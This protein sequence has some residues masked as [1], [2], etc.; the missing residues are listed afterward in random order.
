MAEYGKQNEEEVKVLDFEELLV[1]IETRLERAGMKVDR[2]A[3]VEVLQAEE[4]FL[5]EK[6]VLIEAE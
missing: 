5:V 2:A 1:Y 4:A 3:I 6:G